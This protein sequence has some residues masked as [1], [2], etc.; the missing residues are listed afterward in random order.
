MTLEYDA[1][2]DS[3]LYA[4]IAR[5]VKAGGFNG[6]LAGPVTLLAAEQT[7]SEEKNWTYE[8]GSKNTFAD[9]RLV[10]NAAAY[11]VDWTSAQVQSLPSNFN[12]ENLQPGSVAPTIFLNIGDVKNL[13]IEVDGT[14][15]LNENYSVNFAASM[16]NPKYKKGTK[17]GQFVGICDDVFCPA[18]G[19]V[20]G[21]SLPR[22]SKNQATLGIQYESPVLSGD[23]EIF[24][25]T[26]VTYQSRRITDAMNFAWAPPRYNLS[27]SAG[28]SGDNW[29]LTA[30]GDNITGE[31]YVTS[32][33]FI[34]QF[35]RYGPAVNDGA[36][37]GVTFK[38]NL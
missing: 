11:Y 18:D 14:Y 37:G 23:Y 9:G 35:S 10:L 16:S 27:A 15:I 17:V 8:I 36:T 26:D 2:E 34:I 12:T 19:D 21:N 6:F 33:L 30:W 1:G 4:S 28:I 24:A 3:L 29:S 25:R 13:G 22:Q 31:K 5:G 32:S 38:V 7:F 20:S